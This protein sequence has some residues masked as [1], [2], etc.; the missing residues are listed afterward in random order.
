MAEQLSKERAGE[1]ALKLIERA[2]M[3]REV[4][5]PNDVR[6]EIGNIAKDIDE[7][8]EDLTKFLELLLP[9][10]LGRALGRKSVTITTS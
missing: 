4:P 2:A 7:S 10:I 9:K 5:A 8:T 3:D 1:I 6:R